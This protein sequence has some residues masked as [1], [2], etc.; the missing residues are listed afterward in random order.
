M[1]LIDVPTPLNSSSKH[2]FL[3][4][5]TLTLSTLGESTDKVRAPR[6]PEKT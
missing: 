3:Q 5:F 6:L 2:F 4:E 1:V